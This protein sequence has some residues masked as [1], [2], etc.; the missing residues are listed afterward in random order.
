MQL[1]TGF[2]GALEPL[3]M[4]VCGFSTATVGSI[5]S[6]YYLGLLAGCWLGGPLVE[7]VGHIRAF[8]GFAAISAAAPLALPIF[9]DP[10]AWAGLRAIY[11]LAIAVQLVAVESWLSAASSGENRGRVFSTYMF[12]AYLATAASQFFL[13]LEDP[14]AAPLFSLVAGLS[15][16]CLVPIALARSANPSLP[17]KE[18]FGIAELYRVSPLGFIGCIASGLLQSATYA[19]G[20]VFASLSGLGLTQVSTFMS[21]LVL[22]ALILQLPIGRISDRLDRRTMLLAAAIGTAL[23]AVVIAF[24]ALRLPAAL[25]AAAILFGGLAATIYPVSVAHANDFLRPGDRVAASAGLLFA[26]SAGASVGP[27][28]ASLAMSRLGPPGLYVFCGA[29]A[30]AL[31]GFVVWRMRQRPT[32][33][34]TEKGR[35]AWLSSHSS[36]AA[37]HANSAP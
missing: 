18:H 30:L 16:L 26:Y 11:G 29:V 21:A 27:F 19:L 17:E 22:G 28:A 7:R 1:A 15:A 20:P 24:V 5:G 12:I 34:A 31:A 9:V 6:A 4:P 33:S 8:A 23:A 35:F 25:F 36:S 37:D 3:T 2:C 14:K 32:V 10:W 13:T